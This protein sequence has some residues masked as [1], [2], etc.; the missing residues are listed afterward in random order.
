MKTFGE[1]IKELRKGLGLT[2]AQVA[3]G[4]GITQEGVSKLERTAGQ[5][6]LS[7]T[8]L[9]LAKFFD[10]DPDSL[11]GGKGHRKPISSLSPE[12]AELLLI[13]RDISPVGQQY[14]LGRAKQVHADEYT[15]D[16]PLDPP[17]KH[18]PDGAKGKRHQ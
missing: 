3:N 12:E 14:V 11:L 5:I 13:Y 4:I 2:Q 1:K 18:K 15:R 10:V 8:L 6:P 16:K 9:A 17:G 7:D